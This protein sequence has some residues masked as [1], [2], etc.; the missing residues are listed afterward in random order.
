MLGRIVTIGFAFGLLLTPSAVWG[1]SASAAP[2]A[3][4]PPPPSP[5]FVY[6]VKFLCGTQT[7]GANLFDRVACGYCIGRTTL[8]GNRL[9]L[10]GNRRAAL[11]LRI[12]WP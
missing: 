9:Q 4:L 1:Q 10:L 2:N 12:A 3:N 8:L 5:T 7:Q 11:A 6:S